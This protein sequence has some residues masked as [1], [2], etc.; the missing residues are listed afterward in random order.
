[1]ELFGEEV[2]GGGPFSSCM[3]LASVLWRHRCFQMRLHILAF[4]G[5]GRTDWLSDIRL[6]S[7]QEGWQSGGLLCKSSTLHNRSEGFGAWSWGED[8]GCCPG[9]V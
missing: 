3:H 6:I 1:M 9:F 5:A 4:Y 7:V 8:G 2:G